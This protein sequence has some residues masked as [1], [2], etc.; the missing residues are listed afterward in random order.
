MRA[1]RESVSAGG[2]SARNP[3]LS[4]SMM[5]MNQ[6][7]IKK[8]REELPVEKGCTKSITVLLSI[9]SRMVGTCPVTY[10]W[11]VEILLQSYLNPAATGFYFFNLPFRM[12]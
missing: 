11:I 3:L 7:Q 12:I 1:K 4:L 8:T 2:N 5:S 10:V 6:Q 9:S